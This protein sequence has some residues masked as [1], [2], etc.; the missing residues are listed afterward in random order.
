MKFLIMI[1][2]SKKEFVGG[3]TWEIRDKKFGNKKA[4]KTVDIFC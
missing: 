1:S 2:N 3:Q 4:I